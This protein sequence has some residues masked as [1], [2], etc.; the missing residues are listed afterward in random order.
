MNA[1]ELADAIKRCLN[2]AFSFSHVDATAVAVINPN[3][4]KTV[5][6]SF[7]GREFEVTV[8]EKRR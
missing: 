8:K 5:E 6:V 1:L 4:P 3:K 2:G 7:N